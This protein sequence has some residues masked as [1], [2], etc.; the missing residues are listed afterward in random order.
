MWS[1]IGSIAKGIIMKFIIAA[2][3]GIVLAFMLDSNMMPQYRMA[4]LSGEQTLETI[5]VVQL[6]I[7]WIS[8]IVSTLLIWWIL[9]AYPS[10]NK[11]LEEKVAKLEAALDTKK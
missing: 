6:M 5:K 3:I 2:I 11:D 8:G 7:L 10:K 4:V 9:S 1:F